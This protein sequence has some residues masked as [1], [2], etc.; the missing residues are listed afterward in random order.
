LQKRA[1]FRRSIV[2]AQDRKAGDVLKETDF[3]YKRPGTGIQ[4]NEARYVVGRRLARN[5]AADS[6]L[7]WEDLA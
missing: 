1:K 2:L 7:R 4:P 6:V 5:L 3:L